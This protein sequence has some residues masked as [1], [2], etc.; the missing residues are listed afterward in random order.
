MSPKTVVFKKICKDKSVSE[1]F[2]DQ[3]TSSV[4]YMSDYRSDKDTDIMYD[5]V[6]DH[7]HQRASILR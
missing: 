4:W 3:P 6:Y 7:D 5:V 1:A 2:S